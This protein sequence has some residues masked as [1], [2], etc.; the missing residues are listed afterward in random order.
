MAVIGTYP[1]PKAFNCDAALNAEFTTS[2]GLNKIW[3]DIDFW[4]MAG[5]LERNDAPVMGEVLIQ[6]IPPTKVF[7]IQARAKINYPVTGNP[8]ITTV[9]IGNLNDMVGLNLHIEGKTGKWYFVCGSPNQTN[10]VKIFGVNTWEY[11]MFGNDIGQFVRSGFQQKT[12]EGLNSVSFSLTSKPTEVPPLA[13]S[14]RGFAFGV[15]LNYNVDKTARLSWAEWIVGGRPLTLS[16]GGG[17]G[18]EINLS[19]LQYNSC[20][21]SPI[22]Y[23]G[24][25]ATGGVAAWIKG[26]AKINLPRKNNPCLFCCKKKKDPDGSCDYYLA[27]L[28][29]GFW[30]QGGFPNPSWVEGEA[31]VYINLFDEK[32]KWDGN[33]SVS[34]GQKCTN[35]QPVQY[36][37]T[38]TQEDATQQIGD[39]IISI[40]PATSGN[41]F[42]PGNK[43]QTMYGFKPNEVFDVT[44]RQTDGTILNRTY[45]VKYFASLISLG[46]SPIVASNQNQ[47]QFQPVQMNNGQLMRLGD[48][49][50]P[51][52]SPPL[53]PLTRTANPNSLGMYQYS[54]Q[55][56]GFNINSR[57]LEDTTK[58]KFSVRAELWTLNPTTNIWEKA[59]TRTGNEVFETRTSTFNTGIFIP[60]PIQVY[61]P[62][63]QPVYQQRIINNQ[64]R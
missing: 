56:G 9:G 52:P 31:R 3:F 62:Q 15:G 57:N 35:T 63:F 43:I 61:Q 17:G 40:E 47:N 46:N 32:L 54:I 55:R 37:E 18:F 23:K 24:W 34:W 48:P 10:N 14:G 39:M 41:R 25:Y 5:L 53:I 44:E 33:F 30:V 11:M 27:E 8:Q 42:D 13:G 64:G 26:Y 58:Y 6:Y 36:T 2:G 49:N 60:I 1:E 16:Y 19:L 28:K 12:I 21:G 59:K 20:N 38:Y 29:A 45:Q 50:N 22:G 51:P 4:A 7:D